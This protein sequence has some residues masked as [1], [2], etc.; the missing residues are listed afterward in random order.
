M[1]GQVPLVACLE[2]AAELFWVMEDEHQALW[3]LA[4]RVQDLV[5]EGFGEA[6]SLAPELSMTA[7][8]IEGHVDV[9]AANGVLWG[10][11]LVLTTI[12]SLFPKLE[13]ELELLGSGY[14]IDL[15]RDEMDVF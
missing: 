11:W 10:A 4:T 8:L 1:N 15:T 3:S 14:N 12:L 7:D 13:L 6:L 2:E 9:V 5:V